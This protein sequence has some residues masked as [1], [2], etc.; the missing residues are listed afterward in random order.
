[1]KKFPIILLLI[2]SYTVES[3]IDDSVKHFFKESQF[4]N[5][6]ISPDGSK[7]AFNYNKE[8]VSV[9][10]FI[11]RKT[12][13]AKSFSYKKQD[14]ILNFDWATNE[15]LILT[16][17]K[18]VGNLDTKGGR[19]SLYAINYN[20]KKRKLLYS[21]QFSGFRLVSLLKEDKSHV[22]IETYHF[23][24]KGKPK[25][26]KINIFNGKMNYQGGLPRDGFDG[27]LVDKKGNPRI[28]VE[29]TE[30]KEDEF[31]KGTYKFFFKKPDGKA[32]HEK[33]ISD[34]DAGEVFNPIALSP[35]GKYAYVSSDMKTKTQALYK[36][37]L[38]NGDS[39]LLFH[40]ELVNLGNF[41]QGS[42]D[43]LIAAIYTPDYTQIKFINDKHP[44]T[45]LLKSFYQTFQD[46]IVSIINYSDDNNYLVL[47]VTS[48]INPGEYFLYERKLNKL[49]YI[50]ASRSWIK[51][52]EMSEMSPVKYTT[53]DGIEIH[54]Y[55]TLPK[56]KVA[57]NLPL[58]INPHGGPHGPRDY[59]GFN[60][61]VQF[62]AHNGYAVLQMNFRGS[63]GYGTEFQESGYRKWGREMQNDITDATHWLI[64]KGIAD[65]ERVCI[66]GGS[67]GGYAALSA[68]VKEPDLYKCAIGYVGVYDLLTLK[69]R[70]D[71]VKTEQGRKIIDEFIGSDENELNENSPAQHVN[72]I[73]AKIF[74]AHGEDD[75]RVPMAQYKVLKDSLDK[76]GIPFK[77]MLKDEGHGYVLEK[78]KYDFYNESLKFMHKHIGKK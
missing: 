65:K 4:N 30:E 5:M 66:Y 73:K 46:S 38:E 74:I 77:S 37:D 75:V 22:L 56:G 35:D 12:N 61:E 39:E 50:A 33:D 16:V 18:I 21:A 20:G 25:L 54:G 1:M 51:P 63:G 23:A 58:I 14:K 55:L 31:G 19:P 78:N 76:A 41:I 2:M 53:R 64:D 27:V 71:T 47:R 17:A 45:K 36:Y 9:I 42:D 68:V 43:D 3:N 34:L 57:K 10:G 72:K 28:G 60:P 8:G 24:D 7:L 26:Q 40:D 29:Y 32:W 44:D 62:Y 67:Y 52:S 49:T 69:K 59:W 48:D 6:K 13:E 11:N 70:G 15:R